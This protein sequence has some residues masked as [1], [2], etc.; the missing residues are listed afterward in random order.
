MTAQ[1]EHPRGPVPAIPHTI[2]AIGGAL[3]E[4]ERADFY[5]EV[6][7]ADE[8]DVAEVMRRWWMVAMIDRAP[9]VETSRANA[10]AGRRLVALDE[11]AV[12]LGV[13]G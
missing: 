10:M 5:T 7:E 12:R 8:A 11:L 1:P 9:G 2:K 13:A 6:L 3:S 4:A